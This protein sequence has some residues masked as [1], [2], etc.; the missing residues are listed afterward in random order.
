MNNFSKM[1]KRV[2]ILIALLIAVK[3]IWLFKQNIIVHNTTLDWHQTKHNN[4]GLVIKEIER[5]GYT[6]KYSKNIDIEKLHESAYAILPS[7]DRNLG[8]L[9]DNIA[10][11]FN[12]KYNYCYGKKIIFEPQ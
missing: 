3:Y 8:Y 5:H 10:I 9:L 4:V 7:G 12:L 11:K 2:V 1:L 6:V